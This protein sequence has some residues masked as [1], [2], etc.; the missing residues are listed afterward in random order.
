M[1]LY[2]KSDGREYTFKGVE[3]SGDL[4]FTLLLETKIEVH[5]KSKKVK[6]SYTYYYW[7][8]I[9]DAMS[10]YEELPGKD[11]EGLE[12]TPSTSQTV[13]EGI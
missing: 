4:G 9:L 6:R 3:N 10:K 7:E 2:R 11:G 8:D 1:K 5:G 13:T 12:P